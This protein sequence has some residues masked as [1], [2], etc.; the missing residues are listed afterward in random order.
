MRVTVFAVKTL[1]T[2]RFASNSSPFWLAVA[3]PG[4]GVAGHSVLLDTVARLIASVPE[5]TVYNDPG[6]ACR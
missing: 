3:I 2:F 6:T 4:G 5:E 1:W